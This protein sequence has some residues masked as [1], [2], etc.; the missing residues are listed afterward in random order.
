MLAVPTLLELLAPTPTSAQDRGVG[1]AVTLILVIGAV[2]VAL[3]TARPHAGVMPGL[4]VLCTALAL[5]LVPPEPIWDGVCGFI[6]LIFLL[7][8]R[9]HRQNLPV[10]LGEWLARHRPMMIGAGVTTPAAIVAAEAPSEWS[11]FAAG[12]VG[13]V[14]AAVCVL[15]FMNWD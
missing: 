11:L 14:S 6:C 3:T 12:A 2:S 4:A 10:S 5:V 9:L 15:L 1:L 13:L 8:V 7:A